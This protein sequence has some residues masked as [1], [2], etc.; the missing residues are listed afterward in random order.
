MCTDSSLV[1]AFMDS[2]VD[3]LLRNGFKIDNE[4]VTVHL[5][6]FL[7]FVEVSTDGDSLKSRFE[8]NDELR[9]NIIVFVYNIEIVFSHSLQISWE[10]RFS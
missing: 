9:Y 10:V 2:K 5:S 6:Y 7:G 3:S 8:D 4:N 1:S